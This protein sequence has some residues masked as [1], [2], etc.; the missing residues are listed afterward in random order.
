MKRLKTIL[1][2]NKIY[3]ILIIITIIITIYKIQHIPNKS[4]YNKDQTTFKGII[5]EYKYN[6]EYLTIEI[7]SKENIIATYKLKEDLNIQYGDY[8]EVEGI[9]KEPNNNT[10]PYVFN[11]KEYLNNKDIYYLLNITKINT[12]EH[13]NKI[14]YKIKN[15][16]NKRI[17]KIDKKGYIKAFILGNKNNIDKEIYTNYQTIGVTHLFAL[18]GM[19]I[20]LLST[21]LLKILSKLKEYKKYLIINIIL[22]IYGSIVS[23]PSSL[24]RCLT[25]YIINSINKILKLNIKSINIMYLTICILILK[26]YKIIYDIGF[27][28]STIIVT[29]ILLSNNIVKDDN[30][31]KESFKLS[32]IIFIT[33][34]PISLNNY[35]EVNILSIIY[36][37]IYI[38]YISLIIYPLS[39]ITFIFPIINNLLNILINIMEYI[40]NY[41]NKIDILT[42]NMSLNIYEIIIYYLI[43]IL[44]I[45]TNKYKL[46]II[47]IIIIFVDLL[48]PYLDNN[49]YIYYLDIGQGDSILI[50]P[51]HKQNITLIDTGNINK[52]N[53]SNIRTLLKALNINKIE[54]LIIT[55]GDQDHIGEANDL[56][57]TIKI[58]KVIFNCGT[59]N[60]LELNLIEELNNK[61][62]KYYKCIN[63]INNY[64]FLNTKEYN[65]ENDNSNVIY[66]NI[67]NYK[68]LFMGDAELAKEKDIIEKYNIINI[69]I[70]KVGH[71]G[72]KTSSNE[73]FINKINPKYS[74]ISVGKNN[75]GHPN[76][77]VLENLKESIIYRTDLDGTIL[78]KINKEIK[79]KTYMP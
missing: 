45:K 69:D 19:H 34:L 46:Y 78:I 13:S 10:I 42:I 71:H 51:P 24:K 17:D 64:I 61:S 54:N 7:E 28:Y 79:I 16:I 63:K 37:L 27:Q 55:H 53:L 73:K 6:E 39:L 4:I 31:I 62:I 66:L 67:N 21:I 32:I 18:S 23:F 8:I 59:Y 15:K 25:F 43:L 38:P 40:S 30:K 75:Y 11:Y 14:I 29:F 57:N 77:E 74:I 36:N 56:V 41:L 47:N 2:S 52:N 3:Y 60:E 68:L 58:D 72:S 35:Y 70:L 48:I 50:I 33:S 1:Q 49:Y 26:N 44:L 9:L 5:K 76:K 12:L 22:Y 20:S 65:N